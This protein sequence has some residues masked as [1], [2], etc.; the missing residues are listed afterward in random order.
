MSTYIL[1][2]KYSLDAINSMSAARTDQAN[3][4]FKKFGGVGNSFDLKQKYIL[5]S[6]HPVTTEFGHNRWHI[7]QT[8]NAYS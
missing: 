7:E 2:G 5:V 4:I 3:G 1:T 8:L 6:Q